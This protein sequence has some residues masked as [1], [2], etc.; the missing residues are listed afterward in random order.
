VSA[1]LL[2]ALVLSLLTLFGLWHWKPVFYGVIPAI[3][4]SIILFERKIEPNQHIGAR[5]SKRL[6]KWSSEEPGEAAEAGIHAKKLN[7]I[8][9]PVRKYFRGSRGFLAS[10]AAFIFSLSQWRLDVWG[11]IFLLSYFSFMFS[12]DTLAEPTDS[13]FLRALSHLGLVLALLS[14]V[15]FWI[16][17]F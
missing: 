14:P 17:A 7:A 16:L 15:L 9:S 11:A 8:L 10:L 5:F 12:V 1:V 4:I 2:A 3:I 13:K 6:T